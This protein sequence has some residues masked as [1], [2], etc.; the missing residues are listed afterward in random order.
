MLRTIALKSH[1]NCSCYSFFQYEIGGNEGKGAGL[2]TTR[3]QNIVL[4]GWGILTRFVSKGLGSW[5][6]LCPFWARKN[7]YL[8]CCD[9]YCC[10][11]SPRFASDSKQCILISILINSLS[12]WGNSR[13]SS[14]IDATNLACISFFYL[15][16]FPFFETSEF[17]K[18]RP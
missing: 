10:L 5:I 1:Y 15:L 3:L 4:L 11:F 2:K 14:V 9:C 18:R 13:S 17:H 16:V 8:R 6:V 7:D 12:L